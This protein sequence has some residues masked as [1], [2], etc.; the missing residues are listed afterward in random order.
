LLTHQGGLSDWYP[1]YLEAKDKDE[2]IN[3]ILKLPLQIRPG[4][5]VIYSCLG[6]ILLGNILEKITGKN[7]NEL[8]KEHLFEPLKLKNIFFNPPNNIKSLI[9]ATENG[10][11][12][13][14][15]KCGKRGD[16]YSGWR[17][18]IIWGEVHDHNC[19]TLGGIAG[20][21]GLFSNINDLHYLALQFIKEYSLL[22]KPETIDFFYINY[23]PYS[24]EHW[25]MGWKLATS[26]NSSAG[27]NFSSQS[28]GHTGFTGT[29]LWIDPKKKAIFILLTNR[30][31]PEY[32]EIDFNQIRKKFHDLAWQELI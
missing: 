8:A 30:I 9:A 1:L 7:L 16:N 10:N 21:S 18:G 12:Y 22:F 24:T 26:F 6:Y 20:N 13:E 29:S 27:N 28:I 2:I 31:H 4:K 11:K 3:F 32:K 25:T 19:Y 23:T 15:E 14:K 17:K 5:R